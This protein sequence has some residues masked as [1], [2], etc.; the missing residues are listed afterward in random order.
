MSIRRQKLAGWI[1]MQTA[2]ASPRDK[3]EIVEMR[4]YPVREPVSGR[5]YTIV[6]LRTQSGLSGWGEAGRTSA[7][8]VERAR[9]RIVG[10]PA[11]AYAV[12]STGTLLDAAIHCAMIDIMG[13]AVAAPVY[14]V[15]GGPTRFKA[16]A[17]A[18]LSGATDA[19][20]T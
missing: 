6:R 10:R 2:A 12:T 1:A 15:L 13:K 17:L 11:T 18:S 8:D 7:A 16:R 4:A 20:L 14:R 5:G 19:E 3:H 9:S